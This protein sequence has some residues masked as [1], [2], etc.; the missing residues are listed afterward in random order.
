VSLTT[1]ELGPTGAGTRLLLT[2]QG[3]FLD[4]REPARWR[5]E[6]TGRWLDALAA[7]LPRTSGQQSSR[8]R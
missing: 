1:V 6:G 3:T 7:E 2:E 8:A 4:G 5:E